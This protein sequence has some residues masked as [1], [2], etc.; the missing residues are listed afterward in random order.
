MKQVG[1]K[2]RN[3]MGKDNFNEFLIKSAYFKNGDQVGLF[4]GTEN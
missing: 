4:G 1:F 2:S 3:R